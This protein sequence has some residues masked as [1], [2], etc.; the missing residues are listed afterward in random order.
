MNLYVLNTTIFDTSSDANLEVFPKLASYSA[1]AESEAEAQRRIV[2][3]LFDI[4]KGGLLTKYST[5]TDSPTRFN[6]VF[7]KAILERPVEWDEELDTWV[8]ADE[9][10][11]P[12]ERKA[13]KEWAEACI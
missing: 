5:E 2:E 7:D 13:Q 9:D 3:D 1:I 4:A 11:P 10:V 6:I 8:F 12:E